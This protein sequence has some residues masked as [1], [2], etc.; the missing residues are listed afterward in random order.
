MNQSSGTSVNL[1]KVWIYGAG[2][3][4]NT[5]KEF[6]FEHSIEVVGIITKSGFKTPLAQGDE[7][8]YFENK[9]PVVIGVFNH[10]DNPLDIIEFLSEKGITNCISPSNFFRYFNG[11]DISKYYLTSRVDQLPTSDQIGKV[12]SFLADL[13]SEF[14]LESFT[15]YQKDGQISTIARSA[16]AELQYLGT[17]LPSPSNLKW[18]EGKIN[19]LDIGAFDGDTIRSIAR[20]GKDLNDVNFVC[21]EPDLINFSKLTVC[22]Q[23]VTQM[24]KCLNIAV[25]AAVGTVLF[26]DEGSLSSSS[27]NGNPSQ[28]SNFREVQVTTIDNLCTDFIPT[29]I[30]MDIEGAEKAALQGA[31]QTL[32]SCRPKI[33]ISLYHLPSDI[34]EI[35][36]MLME[37]LTNYEWFIRCY[38]AHGYDTILYG[39]PIDEN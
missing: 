13:E 23:E 1:S 2:G 25:G 39:L 4:A 19:W 36:L 15:S 3:F 9:C 16:E 30:K 12:K 14:V 8:L 22:A 10:R 32:L 29:H 37:L 28:D 26:K 5:I 17:T 31:I 18:L 35:P 6:L 33:A 21:I 20:S 27:S 24:A 38:G 7:N 11:L 34:V